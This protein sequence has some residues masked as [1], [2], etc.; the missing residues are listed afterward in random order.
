MKHWTVGN[1]MVLYPLSISLNYG[2]KTV[3]E[4]PQD[5]TYRLIFF[6][7]YLCTFSPPINRLGWQNTEKD[8][9]FILVSAILFLLS[10]LY[11]YHFYHSSP[12]PS[13]FSKN[14]K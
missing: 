5:T 2:E 14:V 9:A 13:K 1:M 10:Y 12:N 3:Q 8:I 4:N 11:F 7:L 6:F